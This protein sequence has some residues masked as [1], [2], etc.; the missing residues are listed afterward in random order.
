MPAS[1]RSAARSSPGNLKTWFRPAD[2]AVGPEGA[3]YVADW[4][5]PRTGGHSARDK[6][7]SGAI[8]RIAPKG[9]KLTIPKFDL[10]TTAGQIAALK[11]PAVNVRALGF[12]KLRTQRAASVAPVAALLDDANPFVRARAVFLLAQLGPQ[13]VAKAEVQLRAQDPMQRVA[14]FRALRRASHAAILEHARALATDASPAVRRE[15]A[16]SLRDVPLAQ[17]RDLLLTL[18]QG[19][20]GKDRSYLEAWG[21]G[22]TNKEAE[23]YAALA[24]TAPAKDAAM[25]PASHANLV[26]RLTPKGAESAFAARAGATALPESDR[27]AAVTALGFTPTKEAANA[28]LD[29]AQKSSGM[30]KIHAV[31]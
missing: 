20:D 14:A 1:I 29:L 18:A 3:I 2:I 23:I 19:Y 30:V 15:V 10:D 5:D 8:Y 13:G 4:F 9:G 16:L 22:A 31:W 17:S 24:A 6:S 12:N 11:S 27:L 25:W 21:I 26:W 28:L 7:F